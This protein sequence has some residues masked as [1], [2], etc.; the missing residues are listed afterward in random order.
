MLKRLWG[1][2]LFMLAL[3]ACLVFLPGAACGS[4]DTPTSAPTSA[5]TRFIQYGPTPTITTLSEETFSSKWD[6]MTD[7]RRESYEKSLIGARIRWS[8]TVYNAYSD[9]RVFL[10]CGS[11]G[12]TAI[13]VKLTI[14]PSRAI[15]YSKGQDVWFEGTIVEFTSGFSN[16]ILVIENE[17]ILH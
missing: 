1:K 5:P 4:S 10:D 16:R 3:F 14:P 8:C 11:A 6:G 13:Y 15:T 7:V 17:V 12:F 9:G 2:M